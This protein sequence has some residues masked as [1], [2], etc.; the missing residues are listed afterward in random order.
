MALKRGVCFLA[1]AVLLVSFV[2]AEDNSTEESKINRA[3][4]CLQGSIGNKSL[5]SLS[6]QEATF[7]VLALGNNDKAVKKLDSENRSASSNQTCWPRSSC[8][9]K[10]TAQAL[11]AYKSLGRSTTK[12]ENYL[13][14]KSGASTGLS[15]FLEVDIESH[16]PANCRVK[17]DSTERSFSIGQDMRITGDLSSSCLSVVPS[18]Y[19]M[20]IASSC[21]DKS[22]EVTCNQNFITALLYKQSSSDTLFVSPNTHS[23]A[24]DGWTNETITSRCFKSSSGDACDYEGTLWTA[25]ALDEAGIN[26]AQYV[27]YIAAF[28]PSNEQ[29]F[30]SSFLYKLTGGQDHYTSLVQQQ[31][32]SQYWEAT[33]STNKKFY[34]TA[35]AL[36]SLQGNQAPEVTNAKNYML[37]IQGANG[38]W[39]NT[40]IRNT[41]FLLYAGWPTFQ[42]GGG[43]DQT[44]GPISVESCE[45]ASPS[46]SCIASVLQCNEAGGNLLNNYD[47]GGSL[48]C[49]SVT[50]PE[51]TCAQ[52][53]GNIC[54]FDEDCDGAPQDAADGQCCIGTCVPAAVPDTSQ[55][56]ASGGT[57]ASSCD[58]SIE[59]QT[60]DVCSASSDVC[61]VLKDETSDKSSSGWVW[62]IVILLILIALVVLAILFRKRLQI[63]LFKSR[64]AEKPATST[65][66]M[67]RRPP[68]PPSSGQPP[69]YGQ[70]R[71]QPSFARRP[72]ASTGDKDM[73]ETLRKL[74]E[75]SK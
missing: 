65:P 4:S 46:Y 40:N 57:C 21:L 74:R 68:F 69:R 61:C 60:N 18:G 48:F 54:T 53:D 6:L 1:L 56:E 59:A 67:I 64:R 52:L 50:P 8:S 26:T 47:C 62:F 63:M 5:S 10:E 9:L 17:Y 35:L 43:P 45:T 12:I 19:W 23:A 51:E 16:V 71:Q 58:S 34:D 32:S 28:A 72:S 24:T 75:M 29:Y 11:L 25:L 22:Y 44:I 36:L 49:C 27:P 33:S 41:A 7:S 70:M 13:L 73:E 3:Y 20:E 39:D 31:R 15:W 66:M 30:P 38:C 42:A 14:S 2:A 37:N 55:C